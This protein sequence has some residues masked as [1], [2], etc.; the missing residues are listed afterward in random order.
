METSDTDL[1]AAIYIMK[2]IV[3]SVIY[4]FSV[5]SQKGFLTNV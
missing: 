3:P 2:L 1:Q 5:E 4:I